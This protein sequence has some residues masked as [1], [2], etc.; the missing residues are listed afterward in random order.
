MIESNRVLIFEFFE[1]N[2]EF[3][4]QMPIL[5]PHLMDRSSMDVASSVLS[6]DIALF[7]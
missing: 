1:N 4:G 3:I 5:L 7:A 2:S 6:C